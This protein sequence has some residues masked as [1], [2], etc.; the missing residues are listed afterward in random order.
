MKL[1]TLIKL[2]PINVENRL[3][4]RNMR[5]YINNNVSQY[6]GYWTEALKPYDN[7]QVKRISTDK[8]N[9]DLVVYIAKSKLEV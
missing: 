6:I 2:T 4:K 8:T 3:E 5:I 9:G 1:K 7:W